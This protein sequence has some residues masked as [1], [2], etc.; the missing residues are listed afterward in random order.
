MKGHII[1]FFSKLEKEGRHQI[2]QEM[3]YYQDLII[4]R[5]FISS[6]NVPA[7]STS[8]EE[9]GISYKNLMLFCI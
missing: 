7:Y 3:S 1:F 6:D 9:I 5:I 8:D 2:V 4:K